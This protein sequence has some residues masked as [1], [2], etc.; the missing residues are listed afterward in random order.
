MLLRT[1]SFIGAVSAGVVFLLSL[2]L[3]K[4]E[5]EWLIVSLLNVLVI[6]VDSLQRR[7]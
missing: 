4:P 5:V 2:I 6:Q 7:G 1:A 3:G